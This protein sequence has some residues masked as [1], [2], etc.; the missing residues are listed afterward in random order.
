MIITVPYKLRRYLG[1]MSIPFIEKQTIYG[2]KQYL[3][4]KE[5]NN[6]IRDSKNE[7]LKRLYINK[8]NI[9]E[10]LYNQGEI[11]QIDDNRMI[12][13]SDFFYLDLL[14]GDTPNIINYEFGKEIIISL[15]RELQ[16]VK[17]YQKKIIMAKIIIDLIESYKGFGDFDE[18]IT[19][20]Y[21]E[22]LSLQCKKQISEIINNDNKL[23]F[24]YN[25][26]KIIE[27][28]I[29]KFFINIIINLIKNE[30]FEE[31]KIND[32]LK[33]LE[34]DKIDFTRDMYQEFIDFINNDKYIKNNYIEK[35]EDLININKINFYYIILKYIF[36]NQIFIYNIPFLLNTR[37]LIIEII[38]NNLYTLIAMT[39]ELKPSLYKKFEYILKKLTDIE[40]YFDIYTKQKNS[41]EEILNKKEL[42][43]EYPLIKILCG[44]NLNNEEIL[45]DDSILE[46]WN[47]IYKII[48]EGKL[49][50]IPKT[51]RNNFLEYIKEEKNK[52]L[53][54][55]IFNEDLYEWLKNYDY[56]KSE[57]KM[58]NKNVECIQIIDLPDI[59]D[60][61][62]LEEKVKDEDS[63]I[64][65]SYTIKAD[66]KET[67]ATTESINENQA[68]FEFDLF[69]K[70]DKYKVIDFYK[71]L[72]S[73]FD[74]T[75]HFKF[76]KNL[77]KGHFITSLSKH[78]L[79]LYNSL[80]EPKLEIY[81]FEEIRN[82]FEIEKENGDNDKIYLMACSK[83]KLIYIEIN[84]Q[85]YS[86]YHCEISKDRN[87]AYNN[88][89]NLDN[90]N[91]LING[92]K[93]GFKLFGREKNQA[94]KIFDTN[95][96]GGIKLNQNI[97][98]FTSNS[99][100]PK[101]DNK[102]IIYDFSKEEIIKQYDEYNFEFTSNS[103]S[104][105]NLNNI[106]NLNYENKQILLC[107]CK[108]NKKHGIL[109]IEM[110]LDDNEISEHFYETEDF[111]P[112]CCFCPVSLV[113]NN[114]SINDDICKEEN[115][116]V[117]DTEYLFVAGFDPDKRMG[118]IKLYK[119][120]YGKE[121]NNVNL[122]YIIDI[123][124]EYGDKFEGDI[125]CMT[126]S[127]ITGNLLIN[128][129]D[130]NIFLFKPPNLD[131]F[132]K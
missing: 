34:L 108:K 49:N 82:V 60:E 9:N 44:D 55:K 131:C 130:G 129:I 87:I 116:E 66:L 113:E 121:N 51:R 102:L 77:S 114:N 32:T 88:F 125:I 5:V 67:E 80:F 105:I 41:F 73:N 27:T 48:K 28:N 112:H 111:E 21:F 22:N 104:L 58:V 54:L 79:I 132:L 64:I 72:E 85:K 33:E 68:N 115:I 96:A 123:E 42:I 40:Y 4:M 46:K 86:Y 56:N 92:E 17:I 10:I 91:Y 43:Y 24:D 110:N 103:L 11:I 36:K 118:C 71:I 94:K 78:K 98:A 29:D 62:E 127:K 107:S 84:I 59:S 65:Q 124:N 8:E 57:V 35:I 75:P 31:E 3:N 53:L 7:Y 52:Y 37:Q 95:Y 50:K 119:L 128:C 23:F 101:G 1:E 13:L 15:C 61:K 12:K 39:S 97:Y 26:E 20:E 90:D 38:R 14:I 69:R 19:E 81:L 47:K 122:K 6:T 63:I 109:M 117:K 2:I 16:D 100:L 126:Q 25:I 45:F 93:G 30:N 74:K 70:S 18:K 99:L 76:H 106:Q 89:Y 83:K 120:K